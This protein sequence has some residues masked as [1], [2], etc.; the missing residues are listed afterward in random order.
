MFPSRS[1]SPARALAP[2]RSNVNHTPDH[3]QTQSVN[4]V[5]VLAR[6]QT[7]VIRVHGKLVE[8]FVISLFTPL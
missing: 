1:Q 2:V 4:R 3:A 7:G 5:L 8:L 6:S